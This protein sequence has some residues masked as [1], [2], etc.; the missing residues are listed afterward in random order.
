LGKFQVKVR[1]KPLKPESREAEAFAF[2]MKSAVS[3]LPQINQ[4]FI[5]IHTARNGE[6]RPLA[7]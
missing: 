3:M 4:N 7:A 1:G 2:T 5:R 6:R